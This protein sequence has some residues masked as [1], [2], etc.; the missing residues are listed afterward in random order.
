MLIAHD[1]GTSGNKASLHDNGG[2]LLSAPPVGYPP[3]H[4]AGSPTRQGPFH[5]G[6]AVGPPPPTHTGGLSA[7]PPLLMLSDEWSFAPLTW[8]GS[9]SVLSREA[10][11]RVQRD[12]LF[13]K[14][15]PGASV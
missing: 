14:L 6:R 7:S 1:L 2:G 15:P 5:W 9:F 12:L 13:S 11:T 10:A 3:R 8:N 4:A